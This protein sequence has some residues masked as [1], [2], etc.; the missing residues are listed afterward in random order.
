MIADSPAVA[1]LSKAALSGAAI[2]GIL[3]GEG[4][5]PVG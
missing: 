4:A 3:A 2:R 1:F 5:R